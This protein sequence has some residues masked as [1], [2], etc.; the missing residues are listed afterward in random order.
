MSH[1]GDEQAVGQ[2]RARER[3]ARKQREA[4]Y[5]T[6]LG[7]RA[8]RAVLWDLLS[9]AGIYRSA[10]PVEPHVMAWNEG[11]RNAGLK[12]QAEMIRLSPEDYL[13][14][15]AEAILAEAKAKEKPASEPATPESETNDG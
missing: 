4:D 14:A 8:G 3:E 15:Q 9:E 10:G 12:L 11:Q 5:K 1:A 7:T 2:Q 6:V 13:R